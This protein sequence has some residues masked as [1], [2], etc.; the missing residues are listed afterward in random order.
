MLY[1]SADSYTQSRLIYLQNRNFTLGG[2]DE[3][4]Y[5]ELYFDPYENDDAE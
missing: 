1:D 3:M 5:D 2:S 4:K